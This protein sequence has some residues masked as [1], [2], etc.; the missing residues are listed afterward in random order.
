MFDPTQPYP[1]PL[2][3]HGHDVE[4]KEI[5]KLVAQATEELGRLNGMMRLL[6]NRD[7]L[8]KPLLI[9]EAL[10]SSEI[11]HIHTTTIKVLQEEISKW[12]DISWAEKEVLHYREA[13]MY[14]YNFLI[15][16]NPIYTNFICD[17]Q[18]IIE[19]MNAGIRK[20]IDTVIAR[21]ENNTMIPIYTPPQWEQTL[22]DYLHNLEVYINTHDDGLHPLIKSAIIHYQ[23]ECIHPFMDGNWR[24][25][26][27]LIL[28]YL[29]S[30]Q[31]LEYPILFLSKYINRHKKDYYALFQK[32]HSTNNLT[33]MI[34]FILRGITEQA[35]Q[36]SIIIQDIQIL[37]KQREQYIKTT[38][39]KIPLEITNLIASSPF[40]NITI[41]AKYLG[42]ARQTAA[43]YLKQLSEHEQPILH[44][45][46]VGREMLYY[47][48]EFIK[49]LS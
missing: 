47:S 48:P 13:L 17:I 29:I 42:V 31:K 23:F 38:K 14:G 36:T 32:T 11:E 19:P 35:L 27:I 18:K 49:L 21:E 30:T 7:L 25:G 46:K 41:T 20:N 8:L 45:I 9:N 3:P 2:L 4:T 33:D 24:T 43:T 6:P 26:R 5:L 12:S 22:R 28:L 1:L 37:M 34:A 15:Q 16:W 44:N 39:L 40:V 10:Q